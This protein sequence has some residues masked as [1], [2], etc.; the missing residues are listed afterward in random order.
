M[1]PFTNAARRRE[2]TLA[3]EM[4][5]ER[6]AIPTDG[7]EGTVWQQRSQQVRL[8]LRLGLGLSLKFKRFKGLLVYTADGLFHVECCIR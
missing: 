6:I 3:M 5:M 8:S 4:E 7:L 1:F 2:P